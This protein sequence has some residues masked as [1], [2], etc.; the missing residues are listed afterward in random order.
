[1]LPEQRS[2]LSPVEALSAGKPVSAVRVVKAEP[3]ITRHTDQLVQ[4]A[5][6]RTRITAELAAIL[7]ETPVTAGTGAG[8]AIDDTNALTEWRDAPAHCPVL[9][10]SA[11]SLLDARNPGPILGP[12][13]RYRILTVDD[14]VVA[15]KVAAIDGQVGL[16]YCNAVDLICFEPEIVYLRRDRQTGKLGTAKLG[17]N[18]LSQR[19]SGVT[20]S[21]VG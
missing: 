2:T 16:G 21:L 11:S 1:M 18:K 20:G 14:G 10:L 3:T 17:L 19:I 5:P 13:T 12:G 8:H 15:L 9:L 4:E 6:A 7:D